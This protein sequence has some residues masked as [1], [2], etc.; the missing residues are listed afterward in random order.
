MFMAYFQWR[1]NNSWFGRE[2]IISS[3]GVLGGNE[4]SHEEDIVTNSFLT[5]LEFLYAWLYINSKASNL[6]TTHR[7]MF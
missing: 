2:I 3:H 5:R 4:T 7:S 1:I 6:K